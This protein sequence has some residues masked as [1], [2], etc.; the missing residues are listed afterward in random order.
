MEEKK[1]KKVL[2]VE[3]QAWIQNQWGRAL[4][5]KNHAPVV[6]S[7]RVY[8]LEEAMEEFFANPDLDAIVIDSCVSNDTAE[9]PEIVGKFCETFFNKENERK[10]I[11]ATSRYIGYQQ[12]LMAAGCTHSATK[13][14]L[15]QELLKALEEGK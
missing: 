4:E 3:H 6:H 12:R 15:P 1:L 11:I 2:F 7:I 13:D 5:D 8:S 14:T 10:P 9:T